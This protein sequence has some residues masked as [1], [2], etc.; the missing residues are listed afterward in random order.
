MLSRQCA[1]WHI[2]Q[3]VQPFVQAILIVPLPT[4]EAILLVAVSIA[5]QVLR[6]HQLVA[7]ANGQAIASPR[8]DGGSKPAGRRGGEEGS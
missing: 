8:T 5:G 1:W 7:Q 2:Q 3:F 4:M 6:L